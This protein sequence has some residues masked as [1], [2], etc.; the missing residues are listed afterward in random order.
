MAQLILYDVQYCTAMN[1]SSGPDPA[2]MEAIE[3][4]NAVV[5]FDLAM[6]ELDQA[7]PIGRVKLELFVKDV[8]ERE[9]KER[10]Y[11]CVHGTMLTS[12]LFLVLF[13][14]S[15]PKHAKTFVSCVQENISVKTGSPLVTK[16]PYSIEL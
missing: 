13:I 15:A 16:A 12:I 11:D 10:N 4:G 1:A 8:S 9:N 6:G 3:R 2:V 5:F 14:V 7:V